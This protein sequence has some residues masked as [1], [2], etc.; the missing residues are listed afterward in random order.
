MSISTHL[1]PEPERRLWILLDAMQQAVQWA[2][3][4]IAALTAFAAAQ[5]AFLKLVTPSGPLGW[6]TLVCLCAALPLGVFAFSPLS[7][8]PN[9]LPFLE[10]PK[11]KHSVD[12]CLV[13]AD[14]LAKYTHSELIHAL[15]KYL[16]GGVT[17]THYHEDLVGRIVI[18]ARIATRKHR[19]FRAACIVVG[20][21]QIGLLGQFI[22]SWL[23]R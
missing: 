6:L 1:S 10:P 2:D 11:P 12:D 16:G 15:D 9:W 5:L 3:M 4:R 20:I 8:K 23:S 13:S 7:G 14:D 22:G 21:G 17:A 19:L 18:N